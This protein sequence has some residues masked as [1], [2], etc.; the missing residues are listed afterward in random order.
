MD[1]IRLPRRQFLGQTGALITSAAV[2][3]SPL[4]T[5]AFAAQPGE[6]ITPWSDQPSPRPR[7]RQRRYPKLAALG[8]ARLADA[9][10]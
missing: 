4:L 3:N 2:L 1:T 7:G 5:Q 6:E 8:R 10:H 9:Q